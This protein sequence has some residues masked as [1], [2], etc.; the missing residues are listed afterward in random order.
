M[1]TRKFLT[2]FAA[3][4]AAL[5]AIPADATPGSGAASTIVAR[6]VTAE[7]IKSHSSNQPYD[8]V[9]QQI[10]IDPGGKTGWHTHPGNAIAVVKSGTLTIYNGNDPSCTPH[11]YSAGQ[12]YLDPGD[13]FVHLG[14]NETAM[15]LE[16][17]VTYLDVPPGGSVRVDAADPG[18]CAL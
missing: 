11:N 12:V 18:T 6:G 9:V 5:T 2:I 14:R 16:I 15:P 10:T 3:A 4:A 7:K 17:V 1:S 13:G 8:V